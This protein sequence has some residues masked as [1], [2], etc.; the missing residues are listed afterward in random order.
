M[1]FFLAKPTAPAETAF[2]KR[3]RE[4]NRAIGKTRSE[5][6]VYLSISTSMI[7]RYEQGQR[8][9][10]MRVLAAYRDNFGVNLNWLLTGSEAMFGATEKAVPKVDAIILESVLKTV[11]ISLEGRPVAARDKARIVRLAYEFIAENDDTGLSSET[12]GKVIELFAKN[13]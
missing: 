9:P 3:L 10:N 11:D 1:E 6:S 4:L 7:G 12:L 8:E 13:K 2:G 5:L